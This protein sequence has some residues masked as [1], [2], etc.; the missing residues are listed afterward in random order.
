MGGGE[1]NYMKKFKTAKITPKLFPVKGNFSKQFKEL[2]KNEVEIKITMRQN[3]GR[4]N[5]STF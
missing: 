3:N 5:H 4:K 2:H 1:E